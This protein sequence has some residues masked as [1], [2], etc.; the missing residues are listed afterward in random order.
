MIIKNYNKLLLNIKL[1][2]YQKYR[3][4]QKFEIQQKK[5]V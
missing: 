2:K 4:Y 5:W 1:N 3:F